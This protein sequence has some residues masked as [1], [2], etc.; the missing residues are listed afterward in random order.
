MSATKVNAGAEQCQSGVI[1]DV[2]VASANKDG[3]ATLACMRT[4]G[5]G[6]QQACAGNDSRLVDNIVAGQRIWRSTLPQ[7]GGTLLLVSGTIYSVYL[8]RTVQSL[9]PKFVEFLVTTAG[10]GTQVGEIALASSPS[11]PNKAGQ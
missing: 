1:T 8:G 2:Q 6:S 9:T 3:L 5:T 7:A 4:L 11:A 10:A